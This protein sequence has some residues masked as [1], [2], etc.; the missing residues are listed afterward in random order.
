[1]THMEEEK[2]GRTVLASICQAYYDSLG[3]EV[4]RVKGEPI[5]RKILYATDGSEGARKAGQMVKLLLAGFPSVQLNVLYV[6]QEVAFPYDTVVPDT[7][8]VEREVAEK[9]RQSA[10]QLLA[11]VAPEVNFEHIYGR[12]AGEVNEYA[13]KADSDLIVVGSHGK[14]A[15][16]RL[17]LG[18]VSHETVLRSRVPVLV[19]PESTDPERLNSLDNIAFATDGTPTSSAAVDLACTFLDQFPQATMT[20]IYV[21][22][23]IYP[24]RY[25]QISQKVREEETEKAKQ[26]EEHLRNDIFHHYT[27]RF[28]FRTEEGEPAEGICHGAK[29]VHANLL[30]VGSHSATRVSRFFLGSVAQEIVHR[31]TIPVLVAKSPRG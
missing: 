25:D 27:D 16:D 30:I 24:S 8:P 2:T 18:S 10:L 9:V 12:P 17:L 28:H 5:M 29:A 14:G 11:D 26:L 20:G 7:V 31:T 23:T 6:S 1:M 21:M 3:S 22:E 19:V 4:R 13:T 15:V